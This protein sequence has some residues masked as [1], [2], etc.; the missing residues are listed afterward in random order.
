MAAILLQNRRRTW[1]SSRHSGWTLGMS[2][3]G[4]LSKLRILN[5][6]VASPRSAGQTRRFLSRC[7]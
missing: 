5:L 4:T 7:Y 2:R 3:F 1:L 6:R